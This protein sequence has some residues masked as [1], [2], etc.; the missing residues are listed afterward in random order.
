MTIALISMT[1]LESTILFVKLY[2]AWDNY[3]KHNIIELTL[4]G[5]QNKM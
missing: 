2:L 5:R 1:I 4:K 3:I